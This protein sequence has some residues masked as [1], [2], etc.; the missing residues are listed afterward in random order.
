MPWSDHRGPRPQR[1]EPELLAAVQSR[2]DA[3]RRR[4]Q[5]GAALSGGLA[6]LVALVGVL[7]VLNR[8]GENR[9]SKLQVAG[10]AASTTTAPAVTAPA[11]PTTTTPVVPATAPPTT[12]RATTTTARSP[13]TTTPPATTSPS[14]ALPG[15]L[16]PCDPS[17]VVV[18]ATPDRPSYPAGAAVNVEVAAQNR[19]SRACQPVDPQLE[20][21]DGAGTVVGGS[22]VIDRFTMGVPGQPP[23][24]W[25][26]GETLA[27][28]MPWGAYCSGTTRCPPGRYT[29]TAIFGVFRSP[30]AAFS[31]L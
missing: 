31:L 3:I 13:A 30:P 23:P 6:V 24:S 25:D 1:S 17:N 15:P 21:R 18:T 12:R 4:R 29:A 27:M 22:A 10:T 28:S 16:R 20:I 19:S 11:E 26:P 5:R 7:T 8:G 2:A 14:T 9:A